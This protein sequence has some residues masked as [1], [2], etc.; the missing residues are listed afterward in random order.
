MKKYI[1]ITNS[2]R[3]L[4]LLLSGKSVEGRLY[5]DKQTHVLTFKAWERKAPKYPSQRKLCSLDGG[6]LGETD[7]HIERHEKFPKSLGMASILRMIRRDN[8]QTEMALMDREIIDH[9]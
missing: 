4:A 1:F 9:V 6:W 7:L 8:Q 2:L 3:V 5:I